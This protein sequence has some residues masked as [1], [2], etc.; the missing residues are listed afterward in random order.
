MPQLLRLRFCNVGPH[1][2]RMK[3]LTLSMEDLITGRAA[4]STILLRN[5]G[6]KTTLIR[7][8]FWLLCP[9]K[10]MSDTH[11]I[12]E[13]VQ[14]DDRSVLVAEWQMDGQQASLWSGKPE[15]YLTGAFC[16]WRASGSTQEGRRLHRMFF[17]TRVI[18]DEPHLTLEGLP[19]YVSK[20]GQLERRVMA[21]F[22]RATRVRS[23]LST[24]ERRLYRDAE[25]MARD[26]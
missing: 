25:P 9:D 4:H 2:A 22:R 12:E 10:P 1:L 18:E 19:I 14:P 20:Q 13:Y 7:L 11:K 26:A 21:T 16:E 5:G 17:V 3:D 23:Y 8:I 6:G 15:R 24:G